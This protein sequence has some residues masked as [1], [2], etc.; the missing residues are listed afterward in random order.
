MRGDPVADA[1][2]V[3]ILS[4]LRDKVRIDIERMYVTARANPLRDFDGQDHLFPALLKHFEAVEAYLVDQQRDFPRSFA[5]A[6][7]ATWSCRGSLH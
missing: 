1:G 2:R 7:P 4:C 5:Q 3:C 6:P